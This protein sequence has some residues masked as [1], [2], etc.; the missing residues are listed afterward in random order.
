M[1]D[2]ISTSMPVADSSGLMLASSRES[3]TGVFLPDQGSQQTLRCE[4][5]RVE[6]ICQGGTVEGVG[7]T[8]QTG[9]AGGWTPAVPT[10][11]GTTPDSATLEA[12]ATAP[13]G[14]T[15]PEAAVHDARARLAAD[16]VT[17]GPCNTA[18]G[19]KN[20]LT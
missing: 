3:S 20:D 18:A 16:D 10:P 7:T 11:E 17:S 19:A 14:A 5:I 13:D 2:Q 8:A 15:T 9:I 12:P 4:I 6:N 1:S